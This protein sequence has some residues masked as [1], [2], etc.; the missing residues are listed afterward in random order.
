MIVDTILHPMNIR[1]TV[2]DRI[3]LDYSI[4]PFTQKKGYPASKG[5]KES[6]REKH[7]VRCVQLLSF[8]SQLLQLSEELGLYLA[9]RK[10]LM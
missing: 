1:Y 6:I 2:P 8:R 4:Q 3:L 10:D 9:I 7:N 5:L